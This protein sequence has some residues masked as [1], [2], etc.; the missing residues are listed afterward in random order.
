MAHG[1]GR[2]RGDGVEF[3]IVNVAKH[4]LPAVVLA[5]AVG[6]RS[7]SGSYRLDAAAVAR[8]VELLAPAEAC[9]ALKHP[10]LVAWRRLQA[11]L[12]PGDVVVAAFAADLDP[13]PGD[14]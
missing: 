9:T 2:A 10:N 3:A 5:T 14:P 1:V 4:N 13:P 12:A 6:H 11:S 8:A 7:G